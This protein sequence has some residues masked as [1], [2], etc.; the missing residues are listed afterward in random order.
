MSDSVQPMDIHPP[1]RLLCPWDSLS[2]NTGVGCHS[3]LQ[4]DL[5]DLG[6]D[7]GSPALQADSLPSE[8]PGK[9]KWPKSKTLRILNVCENVKQLEHSYTA[10]G[11]TKLYS[12]FGKQFGRQ[13]DN[14][15]IPS[16]KK[17]WEKVWKKLKC[18][19]DSLK[20]TN[21]TRL[22]IAWFQLHNIL[23]KTKL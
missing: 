21:Q 14:E 16:A 22:H 20:V 3:L 1:T 12:H 8:P 19:Y 6:I 10:A 7:S 23:E 2:K 17:K 15:V 4:R 5:S 11:N 13:L 9:T 18:V